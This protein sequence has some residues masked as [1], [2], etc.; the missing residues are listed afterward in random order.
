MG[1][2]ANVGLNGL[3][4]GLTGTIPTS[5]FAAFQA[6]FAIIALALISG[7]VVER[8]RFGAFVLFG[9]CGRY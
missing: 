5:V 2:L 9:G 4:N 7:A 3:T 8:M 6:M 1:S